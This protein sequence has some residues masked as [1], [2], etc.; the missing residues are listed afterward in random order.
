ML[1]YMSLIKEA[2]FGFD[3]GDEVAGL[4]L[5]R[6]A[7]TLG[8]KHQY[9]DMFHW[10]Q[11]SS[12]AKLCTKALV[13]GIEVDY[14]QTLVRK[15]NLFPEEPPWEIEDWPWP[16]R[17]YTLGG[18]KILKDHKPV[19]FSGK[20]QKKPLEM[21]KAVIALGGNE[22]KEEQVIDLFW[23]DA[24]GDA[25]HS[26]F[27]TTL[28]R[29]RRLLGHE[30]AIRYQEGKATLNPHY[31]WVDAW[32]FER[33]LGQAE[34]ALKRVDDPEN[35]ENNRE[36]ILRPA[37]KASDIYKGHFLP[38]DEKYSWTISYRERLRAKFIRLITR[39]GDYLQQT[40]QWEKAVEYYHRGLDV[41][42]FAEE[43]YQYLMIS[44]HR[45]GQPVKAIEVYRRCR[46]TLSAELGIEPSL[47]TQSIYQN[48][49]KNLKI[50]SSNTK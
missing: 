9:M 16:L 32:A 2:Q 13:A 12:M 23:P 22:V 1:E 26:D 20:V 10:W 48:I 34:S 18:F 7:M 50:K 11:P 29:L 46:K 49:I 6:A 33:I 15:N 45:L 4:Q 28:S 19:Q 25:A 30:T 43:Y 44:Y 17:I 40:G 35:Q 21:L 8:K 47:K 42:E 39:F 14:V 36:E 27:T 37:E 24:D 38:A 41:D 3:Q 5:L 31:C